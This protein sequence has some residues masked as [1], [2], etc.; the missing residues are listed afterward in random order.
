MY[1]TYE[2]HQLGELNECCSFVDSPHVGNDR[3]PT[4]GGAQ[5][6]GFA[7]EANYAF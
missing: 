1:N 7:N 6:A 5:D 2:N 4:A 3:Y